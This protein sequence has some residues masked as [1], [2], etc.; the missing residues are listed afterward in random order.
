VTLEDGTHIGGGSGVSRSSLSAG[1]SGRGGSGMT[2]SL[3]AGKHT[4]LMEST[5]RI[6][7]AAQYGAGAG[8]ISK[9]RGGWKVVDDGEGGGDDDSWVLAEWPMQLKAEFE[10]V[11][12]GEEIV[13]KVADPSL[14]QEIRKATSIEAVR[15]VDMRAAGTR[16]DSRI[17]FDALPMDVAFEV[18]VRIGE[19][20]WRAGTAT[21][22]AKVRM[23]GVPRVSMGDMMQRVRDFPADATEADVVLRAST[24]V[25]EEAGLDQIWGGEIVFP[26]VPLERPFGNR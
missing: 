11:P 25:A 17:D 5:V 16:L 26:N 9:S 2:I 6:G 19:R 24:R 1:S 4:A 13:Q 10:V 21:Q 20:E 18:F 15:V 8:P 14:E 12:A 22:Q 23:P 3:P 7:R